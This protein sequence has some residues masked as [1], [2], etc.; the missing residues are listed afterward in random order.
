MYAIR[1]YYAVEPARA[2]VQMRSGGPPRRADRADH[3]ALRHPL[4]GLHVDAAHVRV[5]GLQPEA[6]VDHRITSYNVCYTK[7]LRAAM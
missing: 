6:V 1:S 2:P 7:L 3:R 5:D 4:A